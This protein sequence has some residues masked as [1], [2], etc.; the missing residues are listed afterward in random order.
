MS[1]ARENNVIEINIVNDQ[2]F[3]YSI[4]NNTRTKR[5][6]SGDSIRVHIR[7]L[8]Q[9]MIYGKEWESFFENGEN[10]EELIKLACSFFKSDEGKRLFTIPLTINEGETVWKISDKK[11][12]SLSKCN[13]E[14]ADT[15]MVMYAAMHN[16]PAVIVAKDT[17]V[18]ILLLYATTLQ[19]KPPS[20]YMKID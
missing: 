8:D 13:H 1:S 20:W 12:T 4:T 3:K 2:Y 19:K 7:S 14:E 15:R 16:N 18:F 10:K 9:K 11:V 17:D 5:S 6:L